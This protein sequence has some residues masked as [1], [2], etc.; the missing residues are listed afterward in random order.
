MP[1]AKPNCSYFSELDYGN[2][3]Y[4]VKAEGRIKFRTKGSP[5][6]SP[7]VLARIVDFEVKELLANDEV[8]FYI[9]KSL[10]PDLIIISNLVAIPRWWQ[11]ALC[12]PSD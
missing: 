10:L 1:D 2:G 6:Q 4:V 7:K 11:H 3:K 5:A 12:P 9:Q 8:R